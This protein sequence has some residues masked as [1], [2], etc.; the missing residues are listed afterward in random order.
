[1]AV[2]FIEP[3]PVFIVKNRVCGVSSSLVLSLEYSAALVSDFRSVSL[4]TFHLERCNHGLQPHTLAR[5]FVG[6]FALEKQTRLKPALHTGTPPLPDFFPDQNSPPRHSFSVRAWLTTQYFPGPFLWL[7]F[8]R[9]N[10][11]RAP[12]A[13]AV[14]QSAWTI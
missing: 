8:S 5:S 2:P 9:S 14:N 10:R 11:C 6:P 3:R 1:M 7:P 4:Q 13:A 12:L